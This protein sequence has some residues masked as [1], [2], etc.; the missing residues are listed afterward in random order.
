MQ[1]KLIITFDRLGE[2]DF[3]A[4]SELINTSLTAN[5]NFPL[6]WPTTVPTPTQLNTAFVAYQSAY[7]AAATNDSNKITLRVDARDNLTSILKKIAPYLEVVANGSVP[8]LQTTGYD[9]RR[10]ANVPVTPA[11]LPAPPN[12]RVVRGTLSGSL[13]IMASTL[14]G[15][16]SYE[17]Q[18]TTGDPTVEANWLAAGVF[19]HCSHI[20]LTGLTPGSKVS[21]RMR[22]IGSNGPGVWAPA[23]TIMVV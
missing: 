7:N 3:L 17:V 5:A 18:Q 12:F 16:G 22:G 9:L 14:P 23:V 8:M 20:D 1:P 15:A 10:D 13:T 11:I 21:L 2:S 6:P 19:R 4:K